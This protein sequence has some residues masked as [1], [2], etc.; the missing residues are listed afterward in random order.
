MSNTQG[1]PVQAARQVAEYLWPDFVERDGCVFL[2]TK[3]P[4]SLPDNPTS[5][6]CGLDRT[7]V[8]ALAN[9][10]HVLD[11]FGHECNLVQ[12]GHPDFRAACEIGKVMAQTWFARLS[13][14]FPHYRFRVY[15]T[16]KDNPIVRFH[17]VRENEAV[18]LDEADWLQAVEQ[19]EV[20]V[21]DSDAHHP[22]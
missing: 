4:A 13:R 2:A 8:E 10:I 18:W 14:D 5:F 11:L 3:T 16:E 19:G 1:I 15:Y 17:R 9:H 22:G 21:L 6:P 12:E 7:G 20:I